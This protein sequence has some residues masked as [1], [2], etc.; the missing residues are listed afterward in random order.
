MDFHVLFT[1]CPAFQ[2]YDSKMKTNWSKA[3][4]IQRPDLN[5]QHHFWKNLYIGFSHKTMYLISFNFL[6]KQA[7]S[8]NQPNH[9]FVPNNVFMKQKLVK[10]RFLWTNSGQK[11]RMLDTKTMDEVDSTIHVIINEEGKNCSFIFEL[12]LA[13]NKK[14]S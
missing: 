7:K 6:V 1:F 10:L 12:V 8:N 3:L 11:C 13:A 14:F 4:Y 9:Y 2:I 5:R